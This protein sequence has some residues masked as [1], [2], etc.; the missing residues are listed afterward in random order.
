MQKPT[1]DSERPIDM[2]ARLAGVNTRKRTRRRLRPTRPSHAAEAAYR[3]E[4][5]KIV[6]ELRQVTREVLLPAVEEEARGFARQG[7]SDD[8]SVLRIMMV[9]ERM[10]RAFAGIDRVA[11]RLAAE[12]VRR[13]E[14][15][16]N[17]QLATGIAE[18]MGA[19]RAMAVSFQ[20]VI[21]GLG[22]RGKV[23]AAVVE[24]VDLIKSLPSQ[25]LDKAKGIVMRGASQ[26]KRYEAIASDLVDQ[27]AVSERRAKLIARDQMS[28]LNASITEA[29]QT[30]LGIEEYEWVTSGD[31]RVRESHRDNNGKV[32]KWSNPPDETGHPGEDINCRC[33]AR[34][35][36]RFD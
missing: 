5:L 10:A 8:F 22:V 9:F 17:R 36:L 15:V 4:L 25:Y 21:E 35:V 12:A 1:R 7:T 33:I 19:D 3:G 30:A 29:K 32:F 20:R 2:L 14:D 24:N 26:G 28:K 6:A 27:L 23:E 16:T 31:E 11:N 34:P 18:A 13:Q